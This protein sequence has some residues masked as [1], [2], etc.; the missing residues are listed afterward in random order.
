MNDTDRTITIR[1]LT[2]SLGPHDET[3]ITIAAP[4]GAAFAPAGDRGPLAALPRR[5]AEGLG[6]W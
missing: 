3:V 4:E 6:Q 5:L 2:G 1:L